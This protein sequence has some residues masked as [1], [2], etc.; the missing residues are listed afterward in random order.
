MTKCKLCLTRTA[1]KTNSHIVPKF[2]SKRLFENVTP[3]HTIVVNRSGVTTK[4]QDTPKEDYI[5]CKYCE[6]RFEILETFFSKKIKEICEYQ[7][8]PNKYSLNVIGTQEFLIC[9]QINPKLFLLFNYMIVWRVSISTE[10]VFAKYKLEP[11]AEEKIRNFLDM[12]LSASHKEL[13]NKSVHVSELLNYTICVMKA[14]EY[15][16]ETRGMLIASQVSESTYMLFITELFIFLYLEPEKAAFAHQIFALNNQVQLEIPVAQTKMWQGLV[17]LIY[18]R[19][20]T[21]S[22]GT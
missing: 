16:D 10:L 3:R 1:D 13:F 11:G 14:K 8:Y 7:K 2:L 12:N 22:N 6:K 17:E 18:N 21:D 19:L 20:T 4:Q 9:S 5:F 15:T